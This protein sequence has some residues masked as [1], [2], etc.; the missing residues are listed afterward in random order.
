M[1][2]LTEGAVLDRRFRLAAPLGPAAA[3]GTVW[4]A[5]ELGTGAEVAVK[6]L[7]AHLAGDMVA[8]ARFRLVARTI[9]QLSSPDI[10]RVLDHG[11]ITQAGGF[12][13][14][15][16]VREL[17]PGRSLAEL[18]E[19]APLPV[20]EALRM[21]ATA[22][23]ALAVAHRAGLVHGRIQPGNVIAGPDRVRI[24]DFGLASLRTAPAPLPRYW[25][26]VASRPGELPDGRLSYQAP[27]TAAG[28]AGSPAADVY[29]VG[30]LLVACLAGVQ[31]GTAGGQ[32]LLSAGEAAHL[33]PESLAALWA[34]CLAASPQ[35]RPGAAHVAVMVRQTLSDI[36]GPATGPLLLP[37]AAPGAGASSGPAGGR[38]SA[39]AAGWGQRARLPQSR[40]SR[41][42]VVATALGVTVAGGAAALAF[43][44]ALRPDHLGGA[45]PAAALARARLRL[46]PRRPRSARSSGCPRRSA[47]GCAAARS[48]RMSAS[49]SSTS[50]A[51][52]RRTWPAASQPTCRNWWR[53]CGPR[54]PP[55]SM[56]RPS[57]WGQP[58]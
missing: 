8:E 26:G 30:V 36:T 44:P 31:P 56:S 52:W 48:G 33:V 22:A 7:A 5:T 29:A 45:A 24:T 2:H 10:A 39:G 41:A 32:P 43:I 53:R 19:T 34:A 1:A 40:R 55:G 37:W 21:V 38:S 54:S 15:Y 35:D 49:T 3:A 18:L 25:G 57:P 46:R 13:V 16:V 50:S 47:P 58:S 6:V 51:R 9:T 14:P 20:E 27:E 23:D 28:G 4:R 12:A 11:Q 42:V 17:A